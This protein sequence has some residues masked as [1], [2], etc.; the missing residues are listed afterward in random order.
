VSA[1]K[2][3]LLDVARQR[4][5]AGIAEDACRLAALDRRLGELKH[6]A[7]LVGYDRLAAKADLRAAVA[8]LEAHDLQRR[9]PQ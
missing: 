1:P 5:E 3:N 9:R 8:K 2:K 7:T 6:M 4:L